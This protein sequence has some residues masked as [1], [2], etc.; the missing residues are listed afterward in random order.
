MWLQTALEGTA[1]VR[2]LGSFTIVSSDMK[3]E[4]GGLVADARPGQN[5][6][7]RKTGIES[8]SSLRGKTELTREKIVSNRRDEEAKIGRK[9]EE[10]IYRRKPIQKLP[11][12]QEPNN[13]SKRT[14]SDD[15]G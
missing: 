6:F 10:D 8:V 4:I 12:A 13:Q 14:T 1:T 15:S 11:Q 7:L 2:I 9:R 5:R 3:Y